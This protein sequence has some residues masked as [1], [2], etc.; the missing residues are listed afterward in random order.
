M[1]T[2]QNYLLSQPEVSPQDPQWR[3][4]TVSELASDLHSYA[5]HASYMQEHK[6]IFKKVVKLKSQS[7]A[8][9]N[10]HTI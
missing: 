8:C 1:V 7:S 6:I 4:R 5:I 10:K 3:E 2:W 9:T